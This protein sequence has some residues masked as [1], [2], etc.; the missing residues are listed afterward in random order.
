MTYGNIPQ[1]S[2]N[3]CMNDRHSLVAKDDIYLFKIIDRGTR[4]PLILSEVHK[5]YTTRKC[6][7]CSVLQLQ[8]AGHLMPSQSLFALT[9]MPVH[10]LK[11]V[12]I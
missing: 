1:G 3:E 8:V 2:G 9:E 4:G 6:D 5:K 12:N 11:S 10:S 7:N